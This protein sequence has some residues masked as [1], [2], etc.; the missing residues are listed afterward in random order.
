MDENLLQQP[1]AEELQEE[2]IALKDSKEEEIRSSIIEKYELNEDDNEDLID[3][4]TADILAQRKSFGKV[5]KQKR[6]YRELAQK[7]ISGKDEKPQTLSKEEIEKSL[8]EK[9]FNRDLEELDYS[10]NVK[11][12]VKKICKVN[13][14]SVKQA[15]KDPY[16]QYLIEQ[17]TDEK[18]LDKSAISQKKNSI[19]GKTDAKPLNP[20]NYDFSTKEGRDK[21]EAD[22]KA[23]NK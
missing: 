22:K 2:E 16:I 8:E 9:F 17:E 15:Q 20:D 6:T 1:T 3:K 18:I 12:A 4:L 7:A 13:N 5:V 21:W 11:D 23:R 19:P 10:D 14:L